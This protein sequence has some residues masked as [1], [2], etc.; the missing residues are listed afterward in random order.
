MSDRT[1]TR[2]SFLAAGATLMGA[3]SRARAQTMPPGITRTQLLENSS[4]MIARLSLAPGA[5]ETIHTHPF[6][7]VVVQLGPGDVETRI[8]TRPESGRRERGHVD[9]IAAEMPHAAANIGSAPFDLV[10]IALKPDRTRGGTQAPAEAPA[11]IART[12]VLDN[13]EA[14]VTR[15]AFSPA[16]REPVHSHPFDLV[17]VQISPGR[18]EVLLG[19]KKDV[20]DYAAG[21]VV[22]LP[23]DVPHAVANAGAAA[24]EIM[25]VGVK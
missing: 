16:A 25:S 11:G 1:L 9:F 19:D 6:S 18:M 24:F 20:K 10:T 21:D 4:V 14:R 3:A 22:F 2:R 15:V 5:R 8:G 13:A 23:R 12:P 7:A 17:L